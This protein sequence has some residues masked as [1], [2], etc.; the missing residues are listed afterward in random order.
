MSPAQKAS[1]VA[2]IRDAMPGL[3]RS[4]KRLAETILNFPGQLASYTATE[5]A[6]IA[7]VSNATVTRFVRKIGYASFE[8]ARQAVREEQTAGTALFRVA[9]EGAQAG[10]QLARHAAQ[11]QLNVEQTLAPLDEAEIDALVAAMASAR[12]LWLVGFRAGQPFARYLGWQVLQVRS[13]VT[14]LPRDG[15]TLAESLAAIEPADCVILFAL[16]R[17]PR[18]LDALAAEL[19]RSGAAVA[20]LGDVAQLSALPA[21]WHLPC[22]TAGSGAL[23]NHAGVMAL[24][25]MLASRMIERT[26]ATGRRRLSAIE[27]LHDSLG[28]I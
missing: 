13:D 11:S 23:F 5:L 20:V 10:G 12:R 16:R 8:E 19:A 21:R 24:C 26:G 17:P 7:G 9:G 1:F 28:E 18:L 6:R 14:V 22:A 3:H 25:G 15:E 4:E 2:R 27:D